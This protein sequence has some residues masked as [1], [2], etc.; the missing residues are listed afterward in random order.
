LQYA[1][2]EVYRAR[3]LGTSDEVDPPPPEGKPSVGP[4]AGYDCLGNVLT[5]QAGQRR[6]TYDGENH[7]IGV[8]APGVASTLSYDPIGRLNHI[9]T[10][11]TATNFVWDGDDLLVEYDATSTNVLRR[12]IHGPGDDNPLIWFEGPTMDQTHQQSLIADH[13]GSIVG[14]TNAAGALTSSLTYDPYGST[15]SFVGPR[16]RYTGQIAIPEIGLYYYK[17]R[18]YDPVAQRFLQTDPIGM[19]DDENLYA[20]V[21]DDPVDHNDPAGLSACSASK[22]CGATDERTKPDAKTK[23]AIDQKLNKIYQWA[24]SHPNTSINVH[25]K[26]NGQASTFKVTGKDIQNALEGTDVKIND[27]PEAFPAAGPAQGTH[28]KGGVSFTS[29]RESGQPRSI[30]SYGNDAARDPSIGHE[31]FWALPEFRT[32][33]VIAHGG[34][35]VAVKRRRSFRR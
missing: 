23:K 20:Y 13:Q 9:V 17:A 4:S 27:Q 30:T 6:F 18:F 15:P 8:T 2:L 35:G 5:D 10:N 19:K 26:L 32:M 33:W 14:V 21:H 24:R 7:L 3:W 25:G 22:G 31:I 34:G 11:G 12:F 28:M 1:E 16:F 29:L